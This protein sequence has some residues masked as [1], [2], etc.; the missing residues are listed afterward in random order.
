MNVVI[1]GCSRLGARIAS[2]LDRRG[3]TVTVVDVDSNSFRRLADTYSGET[4]IGTGIDED[5]LINAHIEEADLF[6]AATNGDNRNIM[7]AQ[8]AKTAFGVEQV[9]CRIY[10]PVRTDAFGKLGI[11]TI[12]PTVEM[13][14]LFLEAANLEPMAAT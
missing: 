14:N 8:L 4:V 13:A 9:M 1:M 2:E 12:S 5:V 11:T 10:D 3:N 6:I 7:A